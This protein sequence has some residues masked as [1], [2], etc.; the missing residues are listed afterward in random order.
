M[1]ARKHLPTLTTLLYD[2][3]SNVAVTMTVA[4]VSFIGALAML[5]L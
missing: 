1:Y 3:V 5:K 4:A 2:E